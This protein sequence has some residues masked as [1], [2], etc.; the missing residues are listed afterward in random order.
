MAFSMLGGANRLHPRNAHQRPHVVVLTGPHLVGAQGIATARHLAN[1]NL[2]V[3]VFMADVVKVDDFLQDELK[4]LNLTTARLSTDTKD[5]PTSPVDLVIVAM[6]D[7]DSLFL[8]QQSWHKTATKWCSLNM[9]PILYLCPPDHLGVK[10]AMDIKW[11]LCS[12]LPRSLSSSYG[13][14]YL[15]NLNF[16]PKV[17]KKLGIKYRSPFCSKQFIALHR[18][19]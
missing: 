19:Q 11:S 10:P 2:H 13:M 5:L 3:D 14:V 4:L 9:A 7:D 17:F 18:N 6:D 8:R 16:P 1:Q 12:V 15:L